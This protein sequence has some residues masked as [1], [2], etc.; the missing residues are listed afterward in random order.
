MSGPDIFFSYA[1]EDQARVAPVVA[2]LEARGWSVF[3][4]RRIPA[5][6]TWRSH[7]GRALDAARCVVVAW[8]E[9]SINSKWV[10][11][12]ADEGLEREILVPV[13]F[14][15]VR[16]PRGFRGIQAADLTG[17]SPE[18][19]S[20]AFD[21]FLADLGAVLGAPRQEPPPSPPLAEIPPAKQVP[22]DG[23]EPITLPQGAAVA[24]AGGDGAAGPLVGGTVD[25]P[26]ASKTPAPRTGQSFATIGAPAQHEVEV[27]PAPPGGGE[28][29]PAGMAPPSGSSRPIEAAHPAPLDAAPVGQARSSAVEP[30]KTGRRWWLGIALVAG[31][32]SAAVGY[33][34]L[35]PRPTPEPALMSPKEVVPKPDVAEMP[36]PVR[37]ADDA[38]NQPNTAA[39]PVTDCDR[40]AAYPKED[41]DIARA[42]P[43]CSA[44][45]ARW[46]QEARFSF[47]YGRLVEKSGY[48]KAEALRLYQNAADQ[49]YAV[50]QYYLGS[51]YENGRM[52]AK[53]EA[54]A[55]R[56]YRKAAD[57]GY[58][59]PQESLARLGPD[60]AET[61]GSRPDLTTIP[62]VPTGERRVALVIG[63][64]AYQNVEPL[65]HPRQDAEDIAKALADIGFEVLQGF[66]LDRD[67]MDDF[68]V[69]FAR[70]AEKA[71]LAL[72]YYSGHGLQFAGENYLVPVDGRIE[73]WRDLRQLV[74]LDQLI[75]DTSEASKLAL[76]V[77]DACRNDPLSTPLTRSLQRS[78]GGSR[79]A[80]LGKG[81]AQPGVTPAQT[82]IAYAT[83][84]DHVSYDGQGRN[85]PYVAALLRHLK[86]PDLEVRLLFARVRDDVARETGD[87]QRPEVYNSLGGEEI[88]LVPSAPA[89]KGLELTQLTPGEVRA[90]QRSLGWLG[91][92]PGPADGEASPGLVDAVRSWQ[93]SHYAEA[94]GR[95]TTAEIVALHRRAARDRPRE[96]LPAFELNTVLLR[97]AAGEADA[98]RLLG[99]IYDPA[100][101][102]AGGFAKDRAAARAWYEK[103][104]AQGDAAAAA[105]L[106][107]L[108]SEPGSPAADQREARRWLEQ[109]AAAGEPAAALRLAELLLD[110]QA[111][112]AGQSRAV[113]LLKVAAASPETK[114]VANAFLRDVGAPVVQ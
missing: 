84:S 8:S 14:D 100:F 38:A 82:L 86:T 65:K 2:A 107:L 105:R 87:A 7:I 17:W 10:L 33:A 76:V 79:S 71:D 55:V 110:D 103:A 23:D 94:T 78:L 46:P 69:R 70:E 37:P 75:E 61:E 98:Q 3:W 44:A 5:G 50:A 62:A 111:D 34:Y 47:Q 18:H 41:I 30:T 83:A 90:I 40:L 11:E 99:M 89:L 24:P 106:G 72:A 58:P 54:E 1:R 101:E 112:A 29:R 64:S 73:D 96:P 67:A 66:D 85:S 53:N 77:V 45:L 35:G 42:G 39:A 102:A 12:E 48:S 95:L 92:W 28:E 36:A 81:L 9:H 6:Q 74:R 80:E 57:Q 97:S 27:D 88:F 108:L 32:V 19:A 22:G 26:Q 4:D 104:V 49:G 16:P 63:N 60:V 15:T 68:T 109:A 31:V 51:L 20:S 93:G 91:F 114:G 113:E 52:V 43:A 56:W 25:I 21:S 59:G 13:L